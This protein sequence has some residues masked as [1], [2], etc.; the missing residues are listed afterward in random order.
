M[1]GFC[2]GDDNLEHNKRLANVFLKNYSRWKKTGS[3]T[4]LRLINIFGL[5]LFMS[6]TLKLNGWY[7]KV[8]GRRTVS[9]SSA[10]TVVVVQKRGTFL[11]TKGV[12]TA[13]LI[14]PLMKARYVA[15]VRNGLKA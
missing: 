2:Q 13:L 3:I 12:L 8:G 11:H 5:R 1:L 10:I 9:A 4:F 14:T 6:W 15:T 7:V